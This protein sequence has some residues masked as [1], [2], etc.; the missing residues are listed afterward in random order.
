MPHG[1]ESKLSERIN[2]SHGQERFRE[3]IIYISKASTADEPFGATK[4]N[5][6]LW[7]I[8]FE[9][10]FKTGT[11]ITGAAYQ[12]LENGPAPKALIP[13]RDVLVR[14]GSI[15]I[16]R[17][18]YFGHY[19]DRTCALRDPDMSYFSPSEIAFIDQIIKDEWGKDAAQVSHESHGIAWKGRKDLD[20]IPYEAAYL[21]DEPINDYDI[22]RTE[23]LVEQYGFA[24]K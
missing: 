6:L 10:F 17:S 2:V 3:L 23:Q 1:Y 9:W 12:R 16:Q 18:R 7:R 13:V 21:S 15:E 4:L 5:K 22:K 20:P 8:D 19:Q 24:G 11:A 14:E